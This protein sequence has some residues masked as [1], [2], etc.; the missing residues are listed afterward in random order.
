MFLNSSLAHKLQLT[1]TPLACM[2]VK[3]ANGVVL[4]CTSEVK[5]FEWWIQGHTFHM[6]AKVLDMGAYDLVL[7]MDWLEQFSPMNCAWLE[8]W[9]EF[10]YNNQLKVARHSTF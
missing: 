8:K 10:N 4:S 7:G 5:S 3:V 2:S 1:A 6:D 9:I